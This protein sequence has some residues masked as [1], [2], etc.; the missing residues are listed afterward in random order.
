[1]TTP[2]STSFEQAHVGHPV[3]HVNIDGVLVSAAVFG[4]IGAI[5]GFMTGGPG[6][7]G[8]GG[9]TGAGLGKSVGEMFFPA[10]I[11]VVENSERGVTA[12][13]VTGR[14][15]DGSPDTFIGEERQKAARAAHAQPRT[16]VSCHA[17]EYVI[18][19][20][21][22]VFINRCSAS[23]KT[24]GTSHGAL[25]TQANETVY[26]GGDKITLFEFGAFP[27]DSNRRVLWALG[28]ALD[29]LGVVVA[30]PKTVLGMIGAGLQI[31]A[32]GESVIRGPRE[33]GDDGPFG[34]AAGAAKPVAG[35]AELLH[36][37]RRERNRAQQSIDAGNLLADTLR[38]FR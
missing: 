26:T 11:P 3:A 25:I 18:Q 32:V 13:D 15:V 10:E 5:G 20:S 1:M 16:L 31:A 12:G 7:A 22:S 21:D 9:V 33:E 36:S 24:D 17:G 38:L 27:T 29:A 6:G 37:I 23:R 8:I 2:R 19:G 14:I 28:I 34:R 35:A 4:V 30:P